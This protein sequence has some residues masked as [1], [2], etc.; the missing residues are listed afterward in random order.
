MR[1]V[2]PMIGANSVRIGAIERLVPRIRG[3]VLCWFCPGLRLLPLRA[4]SASGAITGEV[5][6]EEHRFTNVVGARQYHQNTLNAKSPACVWWH[7][8]A[9]ARYVE[10]K[11]FRVQIHCSEVVHQNIDAVLTLA[12]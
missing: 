6:G 12:P 3:L 2:R 5:P 10:F 9:E 1:C 8:V 4:M 7:A 11:F